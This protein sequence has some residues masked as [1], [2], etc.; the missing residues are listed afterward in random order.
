MSSAEYLRLYDAV[1]EILDKDAEDDSALTKADYRRALYAVLRVAPKP[2]ILRRRMT[3]AAGAYLLG[4][5]SFRD[6]LVIALS[7]ALTPR[8]NRDPAEHPVDPDE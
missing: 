6:R 5:H 2:P 3:S 8:K 1:L 7:L 4:Q